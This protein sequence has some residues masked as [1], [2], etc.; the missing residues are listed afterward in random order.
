[1]KLFKIGCLILLW[2]FI[3]SAVLCFLSI[4]VESTHAQTIPT[5]SNVSVMVSEPLATNAPPLPPGITVYSRA[6]CVVAFLRLSGFSATGTGVLVSM[7]I[8]LCHLIRNTAL[9]DATHE[10]SGMIA[11]AVGWIGCKPLEKEGSP[12]LTISQSLY[13]QMKRELMTDLRPTVMAAIA[14]SRSEQPPAAFVKPP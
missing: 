2:I 4:L 8:M 3:L 1:M 7:L 5:A 6:D 10:Q 12:L 11:R 13:D 14:N 9:K